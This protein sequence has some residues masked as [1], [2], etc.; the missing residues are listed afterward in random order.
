MAIQ[1]KLVSERRM[2]MLL[3][4]LRSYYH[5]NSLTKTSRVLDLGAEVRQFFTNASNWRDFLFYLV[6]CLRK[7]STVILK[8]CR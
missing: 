8:I 3:G 7:L 2:S 1:Q 5:T 6:F 4:S